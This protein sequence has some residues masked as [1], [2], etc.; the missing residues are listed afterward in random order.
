MF[1]RLLKTKCLSVYLVCCYRLSFIVLIAFDNQLLHNM[2]YTCDYV[3]CVQWPPRCSLT[4]LYCRISFINLVMYYPI[5]CLS[6]SLQQFRCSCKQYPHQM[7]YRSVRSSLHKKKHSYKYNK[8][9]MLY[10]ILA[11]H[12]YNQRFVSYFWLWALEPWRQ[13]LLHRCRGY[14]TAEREEWNAG[15]WRSGSYPMEGGVLYGNAR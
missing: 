15:W 14:V 13:R 10:W 6:A 12:A 4:Q 8:S 2:A 9:C 5:D 11:G 3:S 7:Q 1:Y